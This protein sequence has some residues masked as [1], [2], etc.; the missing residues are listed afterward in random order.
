MIKLAR[1]KGEGLQTGLL[2]R[3]IVSLLDCYEGL[4]DGLLISLQF[5]QLTR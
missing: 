4:L 2:A 5:Y 1:L 3:L